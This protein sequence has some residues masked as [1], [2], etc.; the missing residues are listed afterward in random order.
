[1]DKNIT[2]ALIFLTGLCFGYV[3]ARYRNQVIEYDLKS[4][5]IHFSE[6]ASQIERNME[7]SNLYKEQLKNRIHELE[8]QLALH[9]GMDEP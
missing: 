2:D 4:T 9:K 6:I 3:V 1:M 8:H 7:K 5:I